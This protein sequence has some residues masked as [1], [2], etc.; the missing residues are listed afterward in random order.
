MESDLQSRG[1]NVYTPAMAGHLLR[2][3]N[4]MTGVLRG[5]FVPRLF[6]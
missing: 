1:P 4:T 5:S 6:E 2:T 3:G